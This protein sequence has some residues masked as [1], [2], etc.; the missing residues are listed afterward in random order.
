MRPLA[1]NGLGRIAPK[2]ALAPLSAAIE[3]AGDDWELLV[4]ATPALA[5]VAAAN[6]GAKEAIPVL[7]KLEVSLRGPT[8]RFVEPPSS[9]PQ[10]P[11]VPDP[12]EVKNR[13][14][15]ELATAALA[16]LQD[17]EYLQRMLLLVGGK[18]EDAK[19]PVGHARAS[20]PE[21]Q[22]QCDGLK[23]V[24]P[25]SQQ[26]VVEAWGVMGPEGVSRLRQAI[27]HVRTQPTLR[28]YALKQDLISKSKQILAD[29]AVGCD[30]ANVR[31]LAV[32]E[33]YNVD[34][35]A[36][37]KLAE[38]IMGMFISGKP[39]HK[40]SPKG[41]VS[42]VTALEVL[43][44]AKKL[45][46]GVLVQ[47]IERALREWEYQRPEVSPE[48]MKPFKFS[49]PILETIC[50]MLGATQDK[51]A[52]APLKRILSNKA[53]GARGEATIALGR[54]NDAAALKALVELLADEDGWVRYNA[55]LGLKTL[56]G[57]DYFADWVY[58]SAQEREAA[59]EQYRVYVKKTK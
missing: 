35:K 10:P 40:S 6:D 4:A 50:W 19:N 52:I 47:A 22:Y 24:C 5:R 46:A 15:L 56:T 51:D 2:E 30:D 57:E 41:D 28:M 58:G 8:P 17:K 14:L 7:K 16:H 39:M 53:V 3:S 42:V 37:V 23:W 12:V 21:R 9:F 29:L 49:P 13:M 45:K 55:Y 43:H 31:G 38:G 48:G 44:K 25:T 34:E 11:D 36:G 32:R 26:V 54:I 27:E 33:L 20:G 59:L 1:A 18:Y